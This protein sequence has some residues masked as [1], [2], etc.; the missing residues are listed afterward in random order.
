MLAWAILGVAAAVSGAVYFALPIRFGGGY[1]YRCKTAAKVCIVLGS[2]GHT[3]EMLAML[4]RI[5]PAP[6]C[7]GTMLVCA[8]KDV[9]SFMRGQHAFVGSTSG[10]TNAHLIA[11][12]A[13][14]FA[15]GRVYP[16]HPA[17]S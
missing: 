17:K 6:S 13:H 9:N 11:Q 14:I 15:A 10:L 2:G 16:A 4:R 12:P 5:V 1:K 7:T 8:E 3:G